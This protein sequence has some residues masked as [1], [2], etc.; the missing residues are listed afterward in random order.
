M[1]IVVLAQSVFGL[2][3]KQQKFAAWIHHS[4]IHSGS[5]EERQSHGIKHTQYVTGKA[6]EWLPKWV[7]ERLKPDVIHC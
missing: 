4:R 3:T 6:E 2:P 5:E 7:K 1:H